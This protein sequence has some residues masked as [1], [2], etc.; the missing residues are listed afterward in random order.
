MSNVYTLFF[1]HLFHNY[2]LFRYLDFFR[3]LP[4]SLA[5]FSFDIVFCFSLK[6]LYNH[7]L[8]NIFHASKPKM[9]TVFSSPAFLFSCTLFF[10]CS[11]VSSLFLL[12]VVVN[13]ILRFFLPSSIWLL[14]LKNVY[15]V[16]SNTL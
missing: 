13:K 8:E 11:L 15:L 2:Y 1:H 9:H 10:S 3:P 16:K 14:R 6:P 4:S 7:T 12:V 5:L